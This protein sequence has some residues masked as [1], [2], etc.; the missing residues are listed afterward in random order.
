MVKKEGSK[1][2]LA[3]QFTSALL[4]YNL[5]LVDYELYVVT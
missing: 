1:Q 2:N 3:L 4:D 5:L